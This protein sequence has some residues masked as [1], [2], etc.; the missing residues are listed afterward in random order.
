MGKSEADK[1]KLLVMP[2]KSKCDIDI[3][4]AIPFKAFCINVCWPA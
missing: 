2:A 1:S 4:G 3:C